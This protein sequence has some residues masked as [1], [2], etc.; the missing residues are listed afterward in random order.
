MGI[1]KDI[2]YAAGLLRGLMGS[3]QNQKGLQDCWCEMMSLD[4]AILKGTMHLADKP[5][6]P[7]YHYDICRSSGVE[8][9]RMQSGNE[10]YHGHDLSSK[11]TAGIFVAISHTALAG[12]IPWVW[13]P[14][15]QR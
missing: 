6:F 11:A 5:F 2:Q 1:E 4:E 9:A 8:K 15:M 3:A 13:F 7:L 14:R 10:R 12:L